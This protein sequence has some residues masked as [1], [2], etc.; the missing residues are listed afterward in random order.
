MRTII[1]FVEGEPIGKGAD[2][3]VVALGQIGYRIFVPPSRLEALA[4][5]PKVKLH[6][7]MA[8]RDDGITLYGLQ[9]QSE[10][11]IFRQLI[12]VSGVGPR[13]ALAILSAWA[14]DQLQ[15]I[16]AQ[17]DIKALTSVPGVGRK[18]AGRLLLELKDKIDLA[19][20]AE[21]GVL[22]L[23]ADAEAALAAL[24]FNSAEARPVLRDLSQECTDVEE[25]VRRAL[26][27]LAGGEK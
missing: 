11:I 3:I 13:L 22:H 4:A 9:S 2:Y 1:A 15:Q 16:L 5:Q 25:L 20:A 14:P 6:T 18:T 26:A 17:E 8:V 27:R 12:S 21:P 24:G 23:L 7:H 10:L 19:Q